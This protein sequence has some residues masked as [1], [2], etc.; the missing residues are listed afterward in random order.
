MWVEVEERLPPVGAAVF[1][2]GAFTP[3]GVEKPKATLLAP[4]DEHARYFGRWS[5]REWRGSVGISHWWEDDSP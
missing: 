1:V 5:S 2:H 4:D 3:D